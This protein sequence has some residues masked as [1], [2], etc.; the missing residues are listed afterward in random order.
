MRSHTT[1]LDLTALFSLIGLSMLLG[2]AFGTPQAP[3]KVTQS[4]VTPTDEPALAPKPVEYVLISVPCKLIGTATDNVKIHAVGPK[5][6]LAKLK[7]SRVDGTNFCQEILPID[8][9]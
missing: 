6:K 8:M 5:S 7:I 1:L 3:V 4:T 9:D 2:P